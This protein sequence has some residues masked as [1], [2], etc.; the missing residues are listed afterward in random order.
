MESTSLIPEKKLRK[1]IE[2]LFFNYATHA[3]ID[4]I[5]APMLNSEIFFSFGDTF[6]IGNRTLGKHQVKQLDIAQNQL[7]AQPVKSIGRHKTMGIIL[8]PWSINL[9][10]SIKGKN[11]RSQSSA[12]KI[13][14]LENLFKSIQPRFEK[15]DAEDALINLQEV[16]TNTITFDE[17]SLLFEQLFVLLQQSGYAHQKIGDLVEESGVSPKTFIKVF[18]EHTGISPLKYLHYQAVTSSLELLKTTD[19]PIT[20]IALEKGFYDQSHFNRVFKSFML[21]SPG[22][23]RTRFG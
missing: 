15:L 22:A 14:L 23:Y 21:T 17:P 9:I 18:T 16:L 1:H 10:S 11:I 3:V 13:H 4:E 19:I 2:G 12:F 7:T 20:R 5:T 8:K 6:Q